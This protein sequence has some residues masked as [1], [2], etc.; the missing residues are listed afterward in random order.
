MCNGK[1]K[2][3]FQFDEDNLFDIFNGHMVVGGLSNM[4]AICNNKIIIL[5]QG[6][7]RSEMPVFLT[8]FKSLV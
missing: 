7:L 5:I 1:K 8:Y 6:L 4:T 3:A 2:L